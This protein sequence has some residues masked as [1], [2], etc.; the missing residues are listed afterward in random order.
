MPENDLMKSMKL[1]TLFLQNLK[2]KAMT[3]GHRMKGHQ[4]KLIIS[5]IIFGEIDGTRLMN[6]INS[7]DLC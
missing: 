3:I 6:R 4:S 1:T 7:L 5:L 2:E